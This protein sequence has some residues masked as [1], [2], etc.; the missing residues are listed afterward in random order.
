MLSRIRKAV[1]ESDAANVDIREA[2]AEHLPIRDE[3]VD[4]AIVNGIFNLNP[5]REPIFH[6]LARVVRPAG[7]VYAAELILSQP[8]PPEARASE[9]DWFA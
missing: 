7:T 2:D 5:A 4:V 1:A 6:E 8:L 3:E 9:S